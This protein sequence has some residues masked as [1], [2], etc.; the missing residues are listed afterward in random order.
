MAQNFPALIIVIP[1]LSALIIAVFGWINKKWCFPLSIASLGFSFLSSCALLRQVLLT[2]P[3]EYKMAGWSAPMGIVY[4]IDH[5]SSLVLIVITF[6]AFMNLITYKKVIEFEFSEKAGAFYT[7]YILFTTGLIGM[8]STGDA[9]NLY[10]LLE[11]ASLTGYALIGLG[12][13]RAAVSTLNYLFVGTI[14]ATF[15]LLGVGYIYIATGTLNMA[16]IAFMMPGLTDSGI[17][18]F[19]FIICMTGLFA[20]MAF[21]PLHGWLPNAYTYAP[22]PSVGLIA[23][24]TTKVSVYV[25]I[26]VG[27][28]VFT[29]EY[30]FSNI[31]IGESI[32]WL[33][34]IGIIAGSVMALYQKNLKKM[35]TYIVIAEVGYMVGGFWLGN[36]LGITGSILHIVNDSVMTLAGFM[37]A[38]IIAYKIELN[39][40]Q[41]LKGLFKKMPFTM[42]AFVV[43]GLSIIGVPPTC[44]FFSK[45]YLISG[46]V[47]AGQYGFVGALLFSS[48]I[49]AVMFFRI[50]EI[51][52]FEPF[53]EGHGH[54][55]GHV[56]TKPVINEAPVTM[57]ISYIIVAVSLIALGL[58]SGD[59]V[60]K[61]IEFAIPAG[62]V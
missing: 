54:D 46:G 8:V 36:R 53:S 57:V 18:L 52:Y 16:E 49:N 24:L 39:S 61:I 41:D 12:D 6:V 33:A 60:T 26:R 11:I 3:I 34:V 37:G 1:L 56:G 10:V 43:A 45:W 40:I 55:T 51:A 42:A 35:L 62:I 7:L 44:G 29:P 22:S 9:F 13:K 21:F 14:G 38:G 58:Y 25:M 17:I 47:A 59:I 48:L 32:V 4:D 20:K 5:L 27:L 23:S 15:Y 30:T 50:F 28:Y 2:G 19:A 31:Q